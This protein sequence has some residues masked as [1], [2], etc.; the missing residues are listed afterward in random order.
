MVVLY[1]FMIIRPQQKRAREHAA[2]IGG[3]KRGD[4]VVLSSGLIGK[5]VRVEDAEMGVE[6]A[7]NVTVKVVKSDDRRGA[8]ARRTGP[9]TTPSPEGER[10]SPAMLTL[11]RWKIGLV[12]ASLLFGLLFTLPN[13]LPPGGRG[14]AAR[15]LPHDRLNLG[16]DLQGGSYLLEEVDTGALQ[17]E[18]LTNLTE[19]VRTKLRDRADRLHRTGPDRRRRSR[20]GSPTRRRWT[21][22][23]RLLNNSLGERLPSG[24]R[25][26]TVER[27][28]DQHIAVAF[29]PQAVQRGRARRGDHARSRSSAS[30]S[31]RW[32]PRSR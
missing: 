6:I 26:V 16:L 1:Y 18:R 14:L 24:G 12:L 11:S 28:P 8:R 5:V 17:K 30:G 3:V 19:D 4:T 20:C 21:P 22:P 32:A 13:L 29:V 31:T 9:P 27:R 7:Q 15:L 23:S 10:R 2:R 25:D